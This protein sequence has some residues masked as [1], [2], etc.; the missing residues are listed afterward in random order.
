MTAAGNIKLVDFGF[1][2]KVEDRTWTLC[3]TPEYLAPEIIQSKVSGRNERMLL[4]LTVAW[5]WCCSGCRLQLEAATRPTRHCCSCSS[6][7]HHHH[8]HCCCR[9]YCLPTAGPQQVRGLVGAGDPHLRNAGR[10]P[11][12]LRRVPLRHLPEDPGGQAGVPQALCPRGA[13]PD[14][15]AADRRQDQAARCVP[16]AIFARASP[17]CSRASSAAALPLRSWPRCLYE[18]PLLLPRCHC[19]LPVQA[20]CAAA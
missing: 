15:Q 7:H 18:P 8:H 10:V 3:G 20:A 4:L 2:K 17:S 12:L 19:P 11:A 13:R 5:R 6:D 9:C 16:S 14:P 1:A